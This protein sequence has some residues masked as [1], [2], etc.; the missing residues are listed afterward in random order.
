M[1]ALSLDL[2]QRIVGAYE[3]KEGTYQQIADRFEVSYGMVK[4][5]LRQQRR[6]GDLAPRYYNCG[7]KAKILPEHRKTLLK[8]LAEKPDLT[9]TQ[10]RDAIGVDCTIQAIHYVLKDM[11]LTYK[12]RRYEPVSKT[13][14]T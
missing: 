7:G 4:K 14:Q 11:G 2:R 5:L 3:R 10:L 1:R 13:A 12:K 8:L 9:L 6:T